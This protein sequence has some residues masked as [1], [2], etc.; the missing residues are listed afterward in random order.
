MIDTSTLMTYAMLM[1]IC[2]DGFFEGIAIGA[3]NH[4]DQLLVI[5]LA[6]I[7]NKLIVGLLIGINLKK[8]NTDRRTYIKFILLF[9]IF[10]PLGILIGMFASKN[11]MSR[12]IMISISSGCFIYVSTSVVVI[13]E[14]TISKHKFIKYISFLFGSILTALSIYFNKM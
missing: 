14:F 10:T 4:L 6:I 8:V 9:A 5:A 3:I 2:I 11:H 7:I 1:S 12:A 13:E